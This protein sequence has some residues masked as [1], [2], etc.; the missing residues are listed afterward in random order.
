M[1]EYAEEYELNPCERGDVRQ[2][3]MKIYDMIDKRF[4]QQGMGMPVD[5]EELRHV[6]EQI[7]DHVK[8]ARRV[9]SSGMLKRGCGE[10]IINERAKKGE[11]RRE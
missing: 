10:A 2:H 11:L 9:I 5:S 1:T 6:L 3:L 7:E 8:D 4:L